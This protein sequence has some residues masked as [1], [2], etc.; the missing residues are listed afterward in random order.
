M[1]GSRS[2]FDLRVFTRISSSNKSHGLLLPWDTSLTLDNEPH[3][4][5][6]GFCL[7]RPDRIC[8]YHH[9]VHV[10]IMVTG[11]ST[12]TIFTTLLESILSPYTNNSPKAKSLSCPCRLIYS[13]L[14]SIFV[15]LIAGKISGIKS[16]G[17][18][19]YH[20]VRAC[21][22]LYHVNVEHATSRAQS[23]RT[24]NVLP[25]PHWSAW[26]PHDL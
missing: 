8:S 15:F 4:L 16:L 9:T 13:S 11:A 5:L 24:N 26:T 21:V 12:K 25:S 22:V 2:N 3:T 23:L 20:G 10:P 18:D 19:G 17:A 6:I 14:G 7:S 1:Q